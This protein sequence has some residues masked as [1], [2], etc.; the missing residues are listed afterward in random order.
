MNRFTI[1]KADNAVYVD[2]TGYSDLHLEDCNIPDDVWAL[3]WENGS[4]WIEFTDAREN[5]PIV[6]ENFPAWAIA[7]K[8]EFEKYDDF[9]K[10]PPPPTPEEWAQR[11]ESI[12]KFLLTQS[13]WSSLSDVN[14][15]NQSE[16]DSYRA[17]LRVIAI[18]PPQQEITDWPIKPEAIWG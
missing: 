18:N 17:A 11:N 13:D 12:A 2:G 6:G 9:K 16:W 10:N 5:E 14:L 7:C 8:A 1:I 4:G 15:Q 3:Q